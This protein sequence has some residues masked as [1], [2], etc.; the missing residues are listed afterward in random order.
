MTYIGIETAVQ[1]FFF[2]L[3]AHVCRLVS[4]GLNFKR[5]GD[6]PTVWHSQT[7]SCY[8]DEAAAG[9]VFLGNDVLSRYLLGSAVLGCLHI[10]MFTYSK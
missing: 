10:Y 5:C 7:F 2:F 1:E 9:N 8:H 6:L 3:P 4:N